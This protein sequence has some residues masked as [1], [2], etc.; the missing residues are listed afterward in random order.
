MRN[1]CKKEAWW[2]EDTYVMETYE[3]EYEEEGGGRGQ[4]RRRRKRG[5]EGGRKGGR[6]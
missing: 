1:V 3:A 5:G 6:E 4:T 2:M